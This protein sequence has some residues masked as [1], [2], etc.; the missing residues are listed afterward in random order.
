MISR[1]MCK[2]PN[3][4]ER[5]WRWFVVKLTGDESLNHANTIQLDAQAMRDETSQK[6]R[7]LDYLSGSWVPDKAFDDAMKYFDF[8]DQ[9]RVR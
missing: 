3:A 4:F 6:F 8:I 7:D 2:L 1:L 9:P 5:L